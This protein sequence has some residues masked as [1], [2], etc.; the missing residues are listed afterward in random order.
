M[1][2]AKR[3]ELFAAILVVAGCTMIGSPALEN[4]P[5]PPED[6]PDGVP[7]DEPASRGGNMA[8]YE[9]SGHT[10]RRAPRDNRLGT[11]ARVGRVRSRISGGLCLGRKKEAGCNAR[12]ITHRP[13]GAI[14]NAG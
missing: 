5:P 13:R 4:P 14:C 12:G 3:L 6:F 8:E 2:R 7:Y 1:E 10:Y 9:Q 11:L